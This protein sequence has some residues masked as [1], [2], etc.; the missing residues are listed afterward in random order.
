MKVIP[1]CLLACTALMAGGCG[2]SSSSST[3]SH[4]QASTRRSATVE[5]APPAL[6]GVRG[7]VLTA[8]E[9]PGYSPQG[10][11]LLGIDAQSWTIV[12][13]TPPAQ[14]ATEGA[15]LTRIGFVAAVRENLVAAAGQE[16]GLSTVERFRSAA[17][18][19]TELANVVKQFLA[20]P[21]GA[22]TFAVPGIPRGRG[23]GRSGAGMAGVNVA[24]VSGRYCYLVG[25][26]GP[27][28]VPGAPTRAVVIAAAQRLYHRVPRV[29]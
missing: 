15:F 10:Q 2:G 13:L 4:A 17:G 12:D 1:P 28:G 6:A 26:G 29:G 7:R 16:S 19:R 23:F 21:P 22:K 24:F 14:R 8:G 9:M 5:S 27:T 20:S 25:A 11:R 3:R 18:A